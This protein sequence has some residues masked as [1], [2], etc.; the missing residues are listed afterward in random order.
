MLLH[1]D[2]PE[3]GEHVLQP[4]D[5]AI[6]GRPCLRERHV[7][8]K[9]LVAQIPDQNSRIAAVCRADILQIGPEEPAVVLLAARDQ[10]LQIDA[11]V[12]AEGIVPAVEQ[13]GDH[14]Q[15]VGFAD[16]Q[17]F[18]EVL[19]ECLRVA[20]IGVPGEPEPDGVDPRKRLFAPAKLAAHC[21]AVKPHPVFIAG[22]SVAGLIIEAA[23]P[24]KI[25]LKHRFPPPSQAGE[26]KKLF[27]PKYIGGEQFGMLTS[28]PS[29]G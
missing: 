29:R 7:V 6:H 19:R 11:A 21:V 22:A 20:D 5:L 1:A 26:Q 16:L 24:G 28:S 3:A 10:L 13:T 17:R 25:R 18:L 12:V 23:N 27:V 8:G 2:L 15:P 4:A 9:R 14:A